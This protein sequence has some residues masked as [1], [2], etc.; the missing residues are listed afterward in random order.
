MFEDVG[1]DGDVEPLCGKQVSKRDSIEIR[2]QNVLAELTCD[3]CMIGIKI[4]ADHRTSSTGKEP[5]EVS[6]TATEVHHTLWP[7]DEGQDMRI[8]RVRV[9]PALL[10]RRQCG[11]GLRLGMIHKRHYNG[12]GLLPRRTSER[13]EEFIEFYAKGTG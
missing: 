9:N 4:Y 10:Y 6:W 2:E 12:P 13:K 8:T 7:S 3:G 1:K 11:I 5:V